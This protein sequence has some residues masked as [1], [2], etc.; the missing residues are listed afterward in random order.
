[1]DAFVSLRS[2]YV[3]EMLSHFLEVVIAY[4]EHFVYLESYFKDFDDTRNLSCFVTRLEY[5]G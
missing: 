2:F 3:Y 1:M 5:N 4:Y